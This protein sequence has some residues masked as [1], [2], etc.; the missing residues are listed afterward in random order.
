MEIDAGY[1]L[2]PP[3]TRTEWSSTGLFG[4]I[5]ASIT[6]EA[7]QRL[8]VKIVIDGGNTNEER[9]QSAIQEC[10]TDTTKSIGIDLIALQPSDSSPLYKETFLSCLRQ[11]DSTVDVTSLLIKTDS[12]CL[13]TGNNWA[14]VFGSDETIVAALDEIRRIEGSQLYFR[15][16][17][18]RSV[19]ILGNYQTANNALP[20]I[21]KKS[22]RNDAFLVNL[23]DWCPSP[24]TGQDTGTEYL[25]CK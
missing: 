9:F 19:K 11:R 18:Y 16:G 10:V 1:I 2:R 25:K 20:E 5:P 6:Q 21:R 17:S 15:S 7:E 3:C 14:V 8:T 4:N 13:W 23:D 24:T 12:L 22:F